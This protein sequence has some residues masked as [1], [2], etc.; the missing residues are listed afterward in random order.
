MAINDWIKTSTNLIV[1]QD[2]KILQD[3][4]TKIDDIGFYNTTEPGLV[5]PSNTSIIKLKDNGMIDIWTGSDQGIRI[6]PNTK[7]IMLYSNRTDIRSNDRNE[8]IDNNYT[9]T[10]RN[11]WQVIAFG[12]V[13]IKSEKNINLE[14]AK[15]TVNLKCKTFSINTEEDINITAGRNT[16]VRSSSYTG[17]TSEK[18]ITIKSKEN[19]DFKGQKYEFE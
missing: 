19:I 11:K 15:G 8:W 10:V 17:I 18:E 16:N 4:Q 13:D 14:A 12:D 9:T 2:T 3:I 6:D 5:H 1:D 7:S